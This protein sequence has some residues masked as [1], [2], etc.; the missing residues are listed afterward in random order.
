LNAAA[1]WHDTKSWIYCL[2]FIGS[3]NVITQGKLVSVNL[4]E[5]K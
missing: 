2:I 1:N 5:G 4:S 3:F